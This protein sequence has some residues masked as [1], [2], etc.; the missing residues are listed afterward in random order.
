MTHT[1]GVIDAQRDAQGNAQRFYLIIKLN[2]IFYSVFVRINNGG[3]FP[4]GVGGGG[5][6]GGQALKLKAVPLLNGRN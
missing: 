4:F 3:R 6:G 1:N 2:G 5:R